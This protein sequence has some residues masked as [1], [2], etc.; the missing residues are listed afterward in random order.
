MAKVLKK[1][2]SHRILAIMAGGGKE[3]P[4]QL[5]ETAGRTAYQSR[6]KISNQSAA[7]FAKMIRQRGHESV[8][9]HSCMMVEFNNVSRGFTHELVRHRLAS[10]T[11]ESTRYVDESNFKVVIPPDKDAN[12]KLVE[13]KF[14]NGPKI[15]VSFQEWMDL[16]EQMYRGLR[17]LDW[18][19]QDARQ[20]LP[21]AIKA[22][23]VMTANL[24]EWRHIFK[25]RT[26]ENA[27]W[28]IR[29]VMRNLLK[30]VKEKI[31]VIFD[32]L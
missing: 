29:R 9:E 12:K 20:V 1:A 4:L 7:K 2:G 19:P 10:F 30:E 14:K 8:L 5:I 6:K 32:D 11:Q 23:I 17:K 24:R 26:A 3:N 13:L 25:L 16:N 21:I 18:P 15:K 22:Q 27:H 31:P 28:E